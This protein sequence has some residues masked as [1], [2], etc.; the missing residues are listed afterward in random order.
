MVRT[1]TSVRVCVRVSFFPYCELCSDE[2][3]SLSVL[4][5]LAR[6]SM[7]MCTTRYMCCWLFAAPPPPPHPVKAEPSFFAR[8][9][10][11]AVCVFVYFVGCYRGT[12]GHA[13]EK[14]RAKSGSQSSVST[15]ASTTKSTKALGAKEERR[16]PRK[17]KSDRGSGEQESKPIVVLGRPAFL[18]TTYGICSWSVR[19]FSIGVLCVCSLLYCMHARPQL[20]PTKTKMRNETKQK[21][22]AENAAYRNRTRCCRVDDDCGSARHQRHR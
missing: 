3:V 17:G 22:N 2:P 6:S 12:R 8:R 13:R 16:A 18:V 4:G 11:L 21:P 14:L 5:C 9:V 15:V 7:K 1:T 10:L 20:R 19:T